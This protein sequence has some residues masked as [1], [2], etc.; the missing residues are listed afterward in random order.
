[1]LKMKILQVYLQLQMQDLPI[2]LRKMRTE[3]GMKLKRLLHPTELSMTDSERLLL[4]LMI[5]LL[6]ESLTRM[7]MPMEKILMGLPVRLTFLN[8]MTVDTGTKYKKLSHQI[9]LRATSLVNQLVFQAAK[10]LLQPMQTMK[11][12]VAVFSMMQG[13]P[14]FLRGMKAETGLKS[15]KLLPPILELVTALVIL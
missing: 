7:K 3:H 11:N 2:F 8:V 5:M 12:Q 14:T 10:Q 6:S 9:E 1:M 15:I 13:Q 4:Y